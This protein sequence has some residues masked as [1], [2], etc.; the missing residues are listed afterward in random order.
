M[1]LV[2]GITGASGIRYEVA[3]VR[4]REDTTVETF[5]IVSDGTRRVMPI[6]TDF[7]PDDLAEQADHVTVRT[8]SRPRL[9]PVR[10]TWMG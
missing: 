8:T 9:P 7:T 5:R 1:K 10:S 2:V 3:V 6:E 4:L